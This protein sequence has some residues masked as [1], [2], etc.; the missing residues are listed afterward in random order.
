MKVLFKF[1][2]YSIPVAIKSI[3][4]FLDTS[5]KLMSEDTARK[6]REGKGMDLIEEAREK[7]DRNK[8]AHLSFE[9]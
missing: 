8:A 3:F 9:K 7:R 1:L 5:P 4:E 2:L 6:I